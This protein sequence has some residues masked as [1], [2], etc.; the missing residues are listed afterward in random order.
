MTKKIK[1]DR[2][3]KEGKDE[4]R[5]IKKDNLIFRTRKIKIYLTN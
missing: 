4:K 3:F 2:R 1:I 5:G